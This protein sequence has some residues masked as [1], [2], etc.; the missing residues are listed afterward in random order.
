M[1]V[2]TVIVTDSD[3]KKLIQREFSS[4]VERQTYADI[5]VNVIAHVENRKV[6]HVE[7]EILKEN[8]DIKNMLYSAREIEDRFVVAEMV[9]DRY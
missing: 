8:P 3:G 1:I 2:H 6:K 5:L 9:F 7:K 4:T